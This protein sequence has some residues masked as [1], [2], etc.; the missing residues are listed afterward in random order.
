MR[1]AAGTR[2]EHLKN[3]KKQV[4]VWVII[5]WT[6]K[7]TAR[8]WPAAVREPLAGFLSTRYQWIEEILLFHL[9]AISRYRDQY[10]G[11]SDPAKIKNLSGPDNYY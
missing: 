3:S 9:I 2:T 8:L 10:F 4:K 7:K 1:P 5:I 11:H 6:I